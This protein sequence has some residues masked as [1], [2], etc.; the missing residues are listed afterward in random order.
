MEN[1]SISRADRRA[2]QAQ[3]LNKRMEGNPAWRLAMPSPKLALISERKALV[4][5]RLVSGRPVVLDILRA[6]EVGASFTS[7]LSLTFVS[8]TSGARVHVSSYPREALPG[9]FLWIPPLADVRFGPMI[10]DDPGS[11]W[12]LTIPM[13]IRTRKEWSEPGQTNLSTQ[14]EFRDLW[15]DVEL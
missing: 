12:R 15:P 2:L 8:N 9:V 3:W 10:F 7:G 6:D 1:T 11:V 13:S 14:K 4:A 5:W